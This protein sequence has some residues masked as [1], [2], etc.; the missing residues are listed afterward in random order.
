MDRV[1][2]RTFKSDSSS[3]QMLKPMVSFFTLPGY[4][5]T[6]QN[7]ELVDGASDSSLLL[8]MWGSGPS[9][10]WACAPGL[11]LPP[12]DIEHMESKL[13]I[14]GSMSP[15]DACLG[16]RRGHAT[17]HSYALAQIIFVNNLFTIAAISTTITVII[18]EDNTVEIRRACRV[19]LG[20]SWI[21]DRPSRPALHQRNY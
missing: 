19:C 18:D 20:R 13:A 10:L 9:L 4:L 15:L 1:T 12:D 3:T 17:L 6:H 14:L 2:Y 21:V 5:H 16:H 11:R 7:P 8:L